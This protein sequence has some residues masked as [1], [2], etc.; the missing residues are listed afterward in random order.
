MDKRYQVFISSTYED[1]KEERKEV[2]QALL[3][4]DCIPVGMEHFLASN[5]D[6]WSLIKRVIDDSD[7]YIVI[8][9][10]R[11]GSINDEGMG[12]TEMEYRYALEKGKPIIGFLHK[13]PKEIK[14]AFTEDTEEGREKLEAFRELVKKKPVSFWTNPSEL[15][16]VVSRSLIKLQKDFPSVG[17]VRADS[18]DN[19]DDTQEILRLKKENEELEKHTSEPE[20]ADA[21]SSE[22]GLLNNVPSLQQ[23]KEF[24]ICAIAKGSATP[25]LLNK[26]IEQARHV[27]VF[28]TTGRGFFQTH[29][30]QLAKMLR[31]NGTLQVL[32][33]NP[34]SDFLEEV[35]RIE[36]RGTGNPISEEF[37]TTIDN[38][39]KIW[40]EAHNFP[41]DT[42]G[43]I[44]IGCAHTML[45][46]TEIICID[47]EDE[48]DSNDKQ[49]WCWVTM[50]MPP[51]RAGAD[52]VSLEC[53]TT[54]SG[55]MSLA[56]MTNRSFNRSWAESKFKVE[57]DGKQDIPYF[58][59]EKLCASAFW[60]E[61]VEVAKE[62]TRKARSDSQRSGILI[63]VAA[64]HPLEPNGTP[65]V[66]FSK[67][68]DMGYE[69]YR[70][71]KAENIRCKFYVP[72][73][74]HMYNGVVDKVSL[75]ES[76][77]KYLIEK[78]V[79][80]EDIYGEDQNV[81]YRGMDGV[82]NSADE[83]F[84]ASQIW[85]NEGFSELICVCSPVQSMRKT[86]HYIAFG[87]FPSVL[88]CPSPELFHDYVY[89]MFTALPYVLYEDSDLDPKKSKLAREHRVNR[90]PGFANAQGNAE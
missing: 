83:C 84:V 56:D 30:Y 43:K 62:F 67:R 9:G 21:S 39:R 34:Y 23:A 55:D 4:L 50:T 16:S 26:K 72:G 46:Q 57:F 6:K 28:Q 63:E 89:E 69:L 17:W 40:E 41:C 61:K 8:I 81:K 25:E 29:I 80:S 18:V 22:F 35:G 31:N 13:N 78:G 88:T 5:E 24:G 64:Q 12:Y 48:N 87:V 19:A 42:I 66:E 36:G 37:H 45:R 27:K 38:I 60:E 53:Q 85:K 54:K 1:L 77:R 44:E 10:G 68:L 70:R 33:P 73:S 76:G 14:S 49:I 82:Y 65:G 7:Y 90:K 86:A 74:L 59:K 79:P 3:E 75:S 20:K 15:G 51:F 32:L 52:S 11:Y 58:Y 47:K 2:I 71:N